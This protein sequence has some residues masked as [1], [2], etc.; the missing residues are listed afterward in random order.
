MVSG[1]FPPATV[2]AAC[3]PMFDPATEPVVTAA[4]TMAMAAMMRIPVSFR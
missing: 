4:T 1:Q 2:I 3:D